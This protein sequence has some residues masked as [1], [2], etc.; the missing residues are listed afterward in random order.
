MLLTT[1]CMSHRACTIKN[2]KFRTIF[3]V[4]PGLKNAKILA[5]KKRSN[6]SN[7]KTILWFVFLCHRLYDANVSDVCFSLK[8]R[9]HRKT[10]QITTIALG[11]M[12]NKVVNIFLTRRNE[13]DF[14][15]NE[16]RYKNTSLITRD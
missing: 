4:Q 2:D 15:T 16:I 1:T 8:D 6:H 11:S 7:L 10:C 9:H 5:S 14:L 3:L 12:S 13:T